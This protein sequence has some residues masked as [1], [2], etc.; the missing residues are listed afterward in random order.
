MHVVVLTGSKVIKNG[1]HSSL[2][3]RKLNYQK[4]TKPF[5]IRFWLQKRS[6]TN[7]HKKTISQEFLMASL[8]TRRA[9][10]GQILVVNPVFQNWCQDDGKKNQRTLV[11]SRVENLGEIRPLDNWSLSDEQPNASSSNVT[12]T[13]VFT[14][15]RVVV[16][17]LIVVCLVSISALV[18]TAMMLFGKIGDRCGCSNTQGMKQLS[19]MNGRDLLLQSDVA[20][21]LCNHELNI[22]HV[23]F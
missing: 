21:I 22:L 9:A 6:E 11:A 7:T 17:M 14:M 13:G 1:N 15:N 8:K 2:L 5:W 3:T 16:S 10:P 23:A 18:L 19:N 12:S 4:N 20:C